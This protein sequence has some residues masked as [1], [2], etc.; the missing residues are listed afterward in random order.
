MNACFSITKS[1]FIGGQSQLPCH[2][3]NSKVIRVLGFFRSSVSPFLM[4][5][6]MVQDAAEN[7]AITFTFQETRKR[8][9]ERQVGHAC[10]W[11]PNVLYHTSSLHLIN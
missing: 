7:V 9:K 6:L 4:S 8:K 10:Y 3:G 2:Y 5:H 1:N 11:V